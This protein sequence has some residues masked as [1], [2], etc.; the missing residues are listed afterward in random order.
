MKGINKKILWII[1]FYFL[2]SLL[3]FKCTNLCVRDAE[4]WKKTSLA[5]GSGWMALGCIDPN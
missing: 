4:T 1:Y 2:V 5:F 3:I